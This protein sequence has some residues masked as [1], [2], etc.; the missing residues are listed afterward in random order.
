M[1][2]KVLSAKHF[3]TKL[4]ATIQASGRLDFTAEQLQLWG[5]SLENLQSLRIH[6]VLNPLCHRVCLSK[7]W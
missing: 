5:L 1:A 6:I 4:K 7:I 3:A 2:N